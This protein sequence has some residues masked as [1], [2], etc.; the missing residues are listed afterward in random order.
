MSQ[1]NG[2]ESRGKSRL[3]MRGCACGCENTLSLTGSRFS[4][5][6]FVAGAAGVATL[7]ATGLGIDIDLGLS[8]PALAQGAAAKPYRVDVHH[9]L[10]PPSYMVAAIANNFGDGAQRNWTVE[11]SIADM[12]QAGV[13]ISMLSVT[14]PGVN[15]T[16]GETARKL[17]RECN[18]YAAKLIAD[19]PGRFGGF[20]ML[21]LTDIDGS[22]NEISYALDTLKLD[23]IG[24]MTNYREKW[25]GHPLFLP[26]MEEL[27]RRKCVV[28]TH[29]STADC[30]VN[31]LPTEP[32][33]LVEWGTDTTRTIGDIVFS[34]NAQ[35]FRDIK[36]IFSHSG[37]SMPFLVE[38]FIR[39]PMLEAKYKS[40]VP[41]GT[42][43]ELTRFYYDTAQTS[44]KAA[45]SA[46]TAI[47]PTS[48]IL[49]GT[50]FPYRTA[51]D[52]VNGL[53]SC[54]VFT[55]AQIMDIER[56]NAVKLLPRLSA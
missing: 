41:D 11:K 38:R 28:Y 35:K 24:L 29:P 17:A 26:V 18:E 25:L 5:R 45:M 42:L 7:A 9:H 49:F 54:G 6:Q 34:G 39:Q 46:L 53:R 55:D 15:F 19:Y 43:A 33:T 40:A 56:G 31:L 16:S 32:P 3:T 50:D 21:P 36:W 47:I 8:R 12:D 20:A 52:H 2:E 1:H 30:C 22:L 10:S 4:R 14:Q 44:N 27:N 37:G 13:A 51:M 23:G 48:Q